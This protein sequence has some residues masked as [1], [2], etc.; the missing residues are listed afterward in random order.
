MNVKL[1]RWGNSL[2]VRLP[3][4]LAASTNFQEGDIL[5]VEKVGNEIRV[6]AQSKPLDINELIS[7]ITPENR[8]EEID[9]GPPVGNEAW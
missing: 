7:R 2:A 9:P 1:S 8:H 5:E 6:K 4:K 3:A